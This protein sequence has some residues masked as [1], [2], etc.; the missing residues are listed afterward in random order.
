MQNVFK[1]SDKSITSFVLSPDQ[2]IGAVHILMHIDFM[3]FQIDGLYT[4]SF[5]NHITKNKTIENTNYLKVQINSPCEWLAR[6]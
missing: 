5:K 6:H 2:K 4:E 3:Q 1:V